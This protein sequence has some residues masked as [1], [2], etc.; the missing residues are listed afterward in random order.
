VRLQ[1]AKEEQDAFIE[2]HAPLRQYFLKEELLMDFEE[3]FF[4]RDPLKVVITCGYHT[5]ELRNEW[6]RVIENDEDEYPDGLLEN[7]DYDLEQLKR[8]IEKYEFSLG[9]VHEKWIFEGYIKHG[10][11]ATHPFSIGF[12][13]DDEENWKF[14]ALG[15]TP[16]D[17]DEYLY[18]MLFNGGGWQ[19]ILEETRTKKT[20]LPFTFEHD[21]DNEY[22]VDGDVEETENGGAITHLHF[23][24][25]IYLR[26]KMIGTVDLQIEAYPMGGDEYCKV[27][28]EDVHHFNRE[29]LDEAIDEAFR[30]NVPEHHKMAYQ[31]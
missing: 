19:D 24:G 28:F 4:V 30:E 26:C 15:W 25:K 23:I 16:K 2:N 7:P 27:E 13:H 9:D 5:R 20:G 14:N 17:F 12:T 21:D 8:S 31:E 6:R 22:K 18:N 1:N 11:I 29:G 3:G 10:D